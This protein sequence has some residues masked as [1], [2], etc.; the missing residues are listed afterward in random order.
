MAFQGLIKDTSQ[1]TAA[2]IEMS[3]DL[4]SER[5]PSGPPDGLS[6]VRPLSERDPQ[7]ERSIIFRLLV[8]K[9]KACAS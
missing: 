4:S 2:D 6:L 8:V 1:G 5:W 7:D 3:R 9:D